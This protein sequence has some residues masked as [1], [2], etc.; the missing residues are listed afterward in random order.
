MLRRVKVKPI[1]VAIVLLGV[2]AVAACGG[3]GARG[4]ASEAT[5]NRPVNLIVP[6][7]AGSGSDQLARVAAPIFEKQLG[8]EMPVLNVVG[9]T[10]N[11]AISKLLT[12][13]PGDQM[14]IMVQDTLATRTFGTASFE[15]EDLAGVCR[16]QLQP[17]GI[18]VKKGAYD[19]WDELA[20][21]AEAQPG[22]LTAAYV[23]RGGADELLLAELA[24]KGYKFRGVP[25]S[26]P[27]ERYSAVLGGNVD[28][29][30]EQLGDVRQQIDAEQFEPLLI[31]SQEPV[32]EFSEATLS[33]EL[34]IEETLPQFRGI[35]VPKD[36]PEA[37]IEAFSDACR[38][39]AQSPRYEKLLEQTLSDPASYMRGEEFMS[40]LAGS[41]E[42][43]TDAAARFGLTE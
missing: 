32:P 11:T 36:A 43:I 4:G 21:A 29:L 27:S 5:F 28:V 7:G 16:L 6:T 30:I 35:V 41:L 37:K 14:A 12:E 34:G 38:A 2:G 19:S 13:R 22:K 3:E 31:F 26:E 25:F 1:A 40:F 15:V 10:G 24:A 9:A 18:M 17:T 42:E 20:E 33:T 39:V 8:I 23:G